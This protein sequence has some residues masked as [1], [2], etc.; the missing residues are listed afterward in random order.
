MPDVRAP[1]NRTLTLT[2]GERELF[3]SRPIR[4]EPGKQ[5]SLSEIENRII[6]ADINNVAP[7]LPRSTVDLLVADPPY[8]LTKNFHGRTF[9]ET[10]RTTYEQWT[11]SWLV[12]LLPLLK[13][14]ASVYICCDW[15]SSSAVEAVLSRHLVL[16]NRISWQREKGRGAAKN[17]KNCVEDIWFATVGDSWHFNPEAVRLR[18]QVLAPYRENGNPKDWSDTPGGRF[19]DTAASN[20]WDDLTIP[21]WSMPENTDHPTQKP[22]K[23]AARLIL[24]SCPPEGL[25]FDPFLGSG[26]TA[27]AAKKLGRRYLGVE[28]NDEY[29]AWTEKR[30]EEAEPGNA[31]QGYRDGVFWERNSLGKR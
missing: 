1:R 5:L 4:P 2:S 29:C 26:T 3:S 14:N 19:R 16:R 24:A 8:N 10:D 17:W 11:E 6:C 9:R 31:I 22:E 18:R 15:K 21:F 28:I 30:L 27:V 20:F 13:P 25:V 7:M 23:L 12:P